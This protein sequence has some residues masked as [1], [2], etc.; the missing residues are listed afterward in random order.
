MAHEIRFG[1]AL[2]KTLWAAVF[3]NDAGTF[4]VNITGGDTWEAWN[5]ANVANYDISLSEGGGGSG[6]GTYTGTFPVIAAGVYHVTIYEGAVAATDP[7][8]GHGV[9]YWDGTAEID[10]YTSVADIA[11]LEAKVDVV[12]ANV[13]LII[14]DTANLLALQGRVNNVYT[15]QTGKGGGGQTLTSMGTLI[16]GGGGDC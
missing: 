9:M 1:Y 16:T 14:V 8:V 15:Q 13:D 5:D 10:I 11:A 6:G 7:P 12:D 2:N 4:K 3:K